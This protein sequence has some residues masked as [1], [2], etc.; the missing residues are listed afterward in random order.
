MAAVFSVIFM[1]VAILLVLAGIGS[2]IVR[3]TD[4][5]KFGGAIGLMVLGVLVWLMT[6]VTIVGTRNTAVQ[7]S[8]GKPVGTLS[9]GLHLVRPWSYTE[10]YDGSLQTLSLRGE[11]AAHVRLANGASADIDLDVQWEIDPKADI[12]QIHLDYKDFENIEPR[13]VDLRARSAA[14][15]VFNTYDPVATF[16]G[17]SAKIDIGA[18]GT[19]IAE[20]LRATLP[21]QILVRAV[22]VLPP[23]F[24][25]ETEEQILKL[26]QAKT[27]T[28]TAQQQLIT[29]DLR[30]QANDKLAQA[31][32]SPG[33]LFQ[34][35][36]D[37]T[38]RLAQAGKTVSTTWSCTGN[39]FGLAVTG[40]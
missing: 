26:S 1:I 13:V 16:Q 19:Q 38:E 23:R 8:F 28:Q 18:T 39:P 33:V 22:I 11:R 31:N 25:K 24:S 12:T 6:S 27:E 17:N 14:M 3:W 9:N 29:A 7:I 36:L 37:M 2:F 21:P 5:E 34:N 30:R 35:C 4:R 15:E 10:S 32:N 40:K 20:K